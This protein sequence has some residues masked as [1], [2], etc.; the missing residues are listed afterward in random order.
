VLSTI[1]ANH[2]KGLV[3]AH[4]GLTSSLISGYH[5]AFLTSATTVTVG[6]A[7]AFVLLRPRSQRPA[8]QLAPAPGPSDHA[9]VR[10]NHQMEPR[11]A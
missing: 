1:A 6:I 11:A 7:L 2:T 5:L 3:A 8:L 9:T 10:A 4:H